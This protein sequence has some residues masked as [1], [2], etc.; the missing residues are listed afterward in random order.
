MSRLE[1]KD[2]IDSEKGKTG[3]VFGLGPSLKRHLSQIESIHEKKDQYRIVSCNNIDLMVPWLN[4]DHW[5]LAQPADSSNPLH[6]PRAAKRYNARRNTKFYYTDCLDLTPRDQVA[7]MLSNIDYIGY[8]QRHFASE[9]CGWGKLPGGRHICCD[10]IIPGRLCIQ[11]EF[12]KYTK[13]EITYGPGDTVGVHMLALS[14]ML[15]HNPIHVTGIDLDYTDGYVNND[16]DDPDINMAYRIDIGRQSI[17]KSQIMV[18][19]IMK[20]IKTIRECA[21]NIGTEIY[22]FDKDLRIN[23]VVEHKRIITST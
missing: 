1:F 17:N 2:V 11:E 23:E 4:Y 5:M 8:D 16:V 21:A 14:V 13:S 6:I 19:R 3:L 18:E 10:G 15:G 22:A 7:A 9:P 20:D 12:A